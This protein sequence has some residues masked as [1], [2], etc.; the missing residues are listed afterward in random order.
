MMLPSG[1]KKSPIGPILILL[2]TVSPFGMSINS[3]E[4]SSITHPVHYK[5][6]LFISGDKKC[7]LICPVWNFLLEKFKD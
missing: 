2:P 5:E 3:L 6:I 1:H 7:K 4:T